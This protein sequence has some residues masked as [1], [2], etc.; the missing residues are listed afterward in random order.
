MKK[1]SRHGTPKEITCPCLLTGNP[2]LGYLRRCCSSSVALDLGADRGLGCGVWRPAESRSGPKHETR[3][4]HGKAYDLRIIRLCFYLA[5]SDNREVGRGPAR[6]T[7]KNLT[8]R[9]RR[10]QGIP[11]RRVRRPA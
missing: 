3:A 8:C 7:G 11:V 6:G 10:R 9:V 2:R 5:G 1:G 4:R